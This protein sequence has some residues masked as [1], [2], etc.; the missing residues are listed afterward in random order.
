MFYKMGICSSRNVPI[1]DESIQNISPAITISNASDGDIVHVFKTIPSI[2]LIDI[3]FG[4]KDVHGATWK[5][6][7]FA[8][9]E[10]DIERICKIAKDVVDAYFAQNKDDLQI[11]TSWSPSVSIISRTSCLKDVLTS[12]LKEIIRVQRITASDMQHKVIKHIV[13]ASHRRVS[14][15]EE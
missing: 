11:R 3:N 1:G 14:Y 5:Y 4:W 12:N 2:Y 13:H 9:S 15:I 8:P 10:T 7:R 6:I